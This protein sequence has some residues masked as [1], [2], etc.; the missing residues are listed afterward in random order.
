[1][2]ALLLGTEMPETAPPNSREYGFVV[3]H[4]KVE[5]DIDFST[6][7]LSGLCEITII[8]Q[9]KD[10]RVI[11]FDARQCSIVDPGVTINNIPAS[12]IHDDPMKKM[13]IPNYLE[14]GVE[15]WGMQKDRLK[16]LTDDKKGDKSLA[17]FIPKKVPI[18]EIDPSTEKAVLGLAQ[19]NNTTLYTRNTTNT[20][21][22]STFSTTPVL[23]PK[24]AAEQSARFQPLIVTIPFMIK[25]FRDGLHFVGLGESDA[26]YPHVY[27]RHSLNSGTAS[28]IFPCI[29][30]PAMRCTWDISIKFSRY[31]GDA[32]KRK[33]FPKVYKSPQ[34]PSVKKEI[35]N[36]VINN[37]TEE[38]EI[39]LSEDEKLF[40]MTVI[41]SGEL[42]N[43][44]TDL[45]DSSK[46]IL[47]F[48]CSNVVAPQH[49]G[50][51][52]GPFETVDLSDFRESEDDD[53][54][55]QAQVVPV[56][57][58]CLPGRS[59]ELRH[60][61]A[62]LAHALD[63]IQL[64]FGS[65][66][67][68]EYRLVFVDD[69]IEDTEHT[70]SLSLCS[71]RLIFGEDIID[72]EM[73]NV[74]KLVHAIS[75]QWIGVSIVPNQRCDRWATIGLA[76][77][78][79][80]LF[81]RKLCGNNE[82]VFRQKQMNDLCVQEDY[83]RP[84][85]YA[86][87]E[88]LHIGSFESKFMALKAP[89]VLSILDRRIIK[90]SGSVG[91]LRV[92]SKI[93]VTSNT[94][95]SADSII[96][97]ESFRKITEK[98]TKYRQTE[99]FWN[100]W[101]FG[102]G[103]PKFAITQKF[104]KK[105]LC[106]EMTI[107]QTQD[108]RIEK[109]Q[110]LER[111]S[112]MREFKE[113]MK[114][115]DSGELQPVFTGPLTIRIHE[116]DGTPYEHI[117]ELREGHAKIEIPYNT[118]Y[119]RL[120]RNRLQKER[121]AAAEH[122][123]DGG[124]EALYYCLGDLLTSPNEMRE[125]GLTDWDSEQEASMA[126]ESYEWL[127]VDADHEWICE[128]S[129]T[130]MRAYMYVSQLQQDRDI[131]AQYES[132][133]YLRPLTSHPLVSTFLLRTLIDRRY[134]YGIRVMGAEFLKTHATKAHNWVGL[135]QLQKVYQ[136]FFCY[137][138]TKMSRINDFSDKRSYNVEKAIARSLSQIR[139]KDGTCPKE[140]RRFLLDMLRFNDNTNNEF[141]D[142][143]KVANLLCALADS[144]VPTEAEPD[145]MNNS[146][147][148]HTDVP[149]EN[150]SMANGT[151]D[152][153]M[154]FTDTEPEDFKNEV[155]EELDRYR[156]MDEWIN[157]YHNILTVTVLDCKQKLMKA[158]VIQSDPIEFAQYLHDGT[159]DFIRIKAAEALV[160]L[161]FMNNKFVL[162]LLL[163]VLSTD[164]SPYIRKNLFEVVCL[165]LA[166]IAFGDQMLNDPDL[167][168]STNIYSNVKQKTTNGDLTDV[169][170]SEGSMDAN[171]DLIIEENVSLEERKVAISRTSSL[172]G[173]LIALRVEMKENMELRKALWEAICSP[174]I[175]LH[176]QLDLLDL[177]SILCDPKTSMTVKL[178]CP[179]FWEAINLGKGVL[180][181]KLTK[182]M[183][184]CP[185][186]PLVFGESP[187]PQALPTPVRL[188][189][190]ASSAPRTSLASNPTIASMKSASVVVRA[191]ANIVSAPTT[192]ANSP[193]IAFRS[194]NKSATTISLR[195]SGSNK[196]PSKR[197][198]ESNETLGERPHKVVK[199]K[200]VN[201]QRV[202]LIQSRPPNP[203]EFRSKPI[204][205]STNSVSKYSRHG[206][207]PK[208]KVH[209]SSPGLISQSSST[210]SIARSRKPLPEAREARKP[211]PGVPTG[212]KQSSAVNSN[213]TPLPT[214]FSA[215]PP[216]AKKGFILK[217]KTG[218]YKG[219]PSNNPQ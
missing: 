211:L 88:I 5:L 72:P 111:R 198:L 133:I 138:G 1:M 116:A 40:E 46:K 53:K 202:A 144:L 163:N 19:R 149:M 147:Q 2:P 165:G 67:F 63:W 16:T 70:A 64:N 98:I 219:V 192:V 65:Y 193:P 164:L 154:N 74:R 187:K 206:M 26:R 68:T 100:Q 30:N 94:G 109:S 191:P 4:Q 34:F 208:P 17:I 91:L 18:E 170:K 178:K 132:M 210:P 183:R 171:G 86:L 24:I 166:T 31:L 158:K 159:S 77:F 51:A 218:G 15:Q 148:P 141:S 125:W 93:I 119:K 169:I 55:G 214:S 62:P 79:T 129:F 32:L 175:G 83:K 73:E 96:S 21:E 215:E 14:W 110:K 45:K 184:T 217:L 50:F 28:C 112:F 196:T 95:T 200:P 43:E 190:S 39:P 139:A 38:Y 54:L 69:Q 25:R 81:V 58:Y 128:K 80:D 180:H 59:D 115:V 140:A 157:S 137:P 131:V 167:Q 87:G 135:Y 194:Q 172:E 145:V 174:V 99:S 84:S 92:I 123:G 182:K 152:V 203:A 136:E 102:A 204:S 142:H 56:L 197:D 205:K 29:D 75:N 57:G 124:E 121:A 8:P 22:L 89:L 48:L 212:H 126:Q 130:N 97:T 105:R 156:R 213:R 78:M 3:S 113:D 44:T 216:P 199:L 143:F 188:S 6:Q 127:R 7:S 20:P 150:T 114:G 186:K 104:N 185:L 103:C 155:I 117:I 82:Y 76:Y 108:K 118:K 101:V 60:T 177:C 66:P 146:A 176:E 106:V 41:C 179:K 23:T 153:T 90:A 11:R 52:I 189:I 27:T 195:P 151:L 47:S 61:C 168:R 134:F 107:T 36:A 33:Q 42:I 9:T 209:S 181:F 49:I 207:S 13:E 162:K 201:M 35:S 85:L 10:L 173:A 120:K 71:S 160:D 122:A 161:G 37:M 12:H